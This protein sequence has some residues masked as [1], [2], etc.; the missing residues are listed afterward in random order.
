MTERK[1]LR[2]KNPADVLAMVP[3]LLGFH[4][5]D[6]LVLLTLGEADR[7]FHA[8][9]DL[10]ATPEHLPQVAEYLSSVAARHGVRRA[11]VVVYSSDGP[12]AAAAAAALGERL[13]QAGVRVALAVRADGH[14]WFCL[15]DCDVCPPAGTPYDVRTHPFAAEA[16]V[17]GRVTYRSREALRDSLVG[18]DRD[19]RA[20]VCRAAD[21]ALERFA[22]AGRGQGGPLAPDRARAHLVAEGQWLGHR[23]RQF[24]DDGVRLAADDVGR[25]L[26]A[27]VSVHVRDVAWAEMTHDN[28]VRHVDLWRDVVRRSPTDLL[29][30]PA[31]LLGFAAWL[32]GDGALAWCAV[33]RCR[34]AEPDYN[35]A[36]LLAD[37]LTG[38]VPPSAWQPFGRE[39]LPLFAG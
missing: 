29:A 12:P 20:E 14:R 33:D 6:S 21:R 23:V 39:H 26:V 22:R 10:P 3:Y 18:T 38:A 31:A 11:A 4:P 5:E 9:V 7:P 30:A 1:T 28:A 32:S 24:L 19:D 35:L 16:V 34:E 13:D 17:D 37:A 2:A 15:D 27:M 25:M 8:R 36:G